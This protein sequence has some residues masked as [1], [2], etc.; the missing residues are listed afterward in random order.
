MIFCIAD[1][2]QTALR[3]L[4]AQEQKAVKETVFD[5]QMN[6]AAPGLQFHRIDKSKDS[7]FWSMRVNRDIRLIVHKTQDSFLICYVAHHDDAYVWAERRRIETHPTTGAAQIVEVRERVQEIVVHKPA[8]AERPATPTRVV[9]PPLFPGITDE[10]LLTY[11][12][13]VDWLADAKSATEETIFDLAEHL[14]REAAEALLDLAVGAKP[15]V[16]AAIAPDAVSP[17][18]H[19]DAQ[20]RFRVMEDVEELRRALDFPWDQWT[21]FLHPSQ[22]QVV[23]QSF[24]GPARVSGSAGTGKTVVAL[25]RAANILRQHSQVRLLLTTFSLPLANALDGKLRILTGEETGIVPRVTVLPFKGAAYELFALAFGHHP[26]AATEDQIRGALKT[27]AGEESMASFTPR[28][29]ASEWLNV[30]DAWQLQ[31]LEA[32]Q[33]VPRLGR[34]NRLGVRQREKLWPVFVRAKQIIEAQ[35]LLTWPSIFGQVTAHFSQRANK[36]FTHAVIDEAQ[37]L[38]V[39]ELRMLAAITPNGPDALFF[40]GDLGQRIFQEPFSWKALGVDIRGRSRTLKVNYRTSHQIR[41]AADRLLPRTVQDVDGNE[42]DRRGTV[43]VFN[44]PDPEVRTYGDSEHEIEGVAGWIK[45]AVADGIAPAE[46][47]IFVRS[48]DQLARARAAVKAAGQTQMELSERLEQPQGRIAI[49]A[50]HLAKGLEYKAVAVMACDDDVL[51]L[52]ERIETVADEA[53]LDEVHDTERNLFYVACTR[54]RD[55]LLVSG[56]QPASEFFAD[57]SAKPA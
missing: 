39:P 6:P 50:M 48:N 34:K 22:R 19:P 7:N 12:V 53:E 31:T 25:H 10:E 37:D 1:S 56:V 8:E 43:S 15:Q 27:A 44:G 52:Q 28:F 54:A 30:V 35:G 3:R 45:R 36:P 33:G 41:Q 42:Q 38:G 17:F 55:R 26:R 24:S 47:G 40:A 2:F 49:G 23:E 46:I 9:P 13:P 18:E 29:L 20:R 5:L 51:P 21:V 11:G 16:P 4:S 57:F 32:Y 14:P